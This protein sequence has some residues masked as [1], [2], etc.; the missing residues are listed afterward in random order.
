MEEVFEGFGK[1]GEHPERKGEGRFYNWRI[2]MTIGAILVSIWS[3]LEVLFSSPHLWHEM[4]LIMCL[5][6]RKSSHDVELYFGGQG[7]KRPHFSSKA[8]QIQ[9]NRVSRKKPRFL[10]Q[11]LSPHQSPPC[12]TLIQQ[13]A[14][15]LIQAIDHQSDDVCTMILRPPRRDTALQTSSVTTNPIDPRS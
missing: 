11:T 6:R 13:P 12:Q 8:S 5:N 7:S 3:R 9:G 15:Q 1:D 4:G 2:H 10:S 14:L